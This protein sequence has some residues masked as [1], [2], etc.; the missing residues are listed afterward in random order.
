MTALTL[1]ALG[2]SKEDITD[3]L[4]DHLASQVLAGKTWDE[5]GNEEWADSQFKR[6]LD[7]NIKKQ[8]N[9]SIAAMAAVQVLPNVA[10]Y[11]ETLTMQQTNSWGEKTGKPVTF[12]EYLV[13][14]ADAYMREDVNYE[15]K[16]KEE[17]S[18]NWSKHS[19]RIT[20]LV[21]RHLQL[22]IESTMK[23]ALAN[24]NSSIVGGLEAA[25]KHALK[26]VTEKLA[27]TVKTK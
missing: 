15:G 24:A 10:T 17:S 23:Q 19:T 14:R 6:K 16:P 3:R 8:V 2:L 7:E 5:D 12:I 18:Y 22:S 27:V 11:V 26:E 9:E 4:I 25:V 21:N 1:E 13:Q 20:Y